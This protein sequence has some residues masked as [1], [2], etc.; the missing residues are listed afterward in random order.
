MATSAFL[1]LLDLIRDLLAACSGERNKIA[2]IGISAP[3]RW[4][5]AMASWLLPKTSLDGLTTSLRGIVEDTFKIAT[6]LERDCE[7][8]GISRRNG[9]GRRPH[10]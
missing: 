3:G 6:F 4:A 7:R 2:G 9:F 5:R 8:L 1:C 10:D